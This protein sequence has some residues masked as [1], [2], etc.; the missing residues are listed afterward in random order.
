M[1]K[2][3]STEGFRT[4]RT[5]S[6]EGAAKCS[7]K[8]LSPVD[9]RQCIGTS[10]YSFSMKYGLPGGQRGLS[11]RHQPIPPLKKEGNDKA[12]NTSKEYLA[13]LH[14]LQKAAAPAG[15]NRLFLASH[16]R[17]FSHDNQLSFIHLVILLHSFHNLYFHPISIQKAYSI[18]ASWYGLPLDI[19]LLFLL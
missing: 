10:K 7:T 16:C 18:N 12:S 2:E 15:S 4:R 8:F 13:C 9:R 11:Q 3:S 1:L 6:K 19:K 14:S 5:P 17:H